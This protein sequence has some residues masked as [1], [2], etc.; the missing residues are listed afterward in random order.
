MEFVIVVGAALG[1]R[2][3]VDQLAKRGALSPRQ[4]AVALPVLWLVLGLGLAATGGTGTSWQIAGVLLGLFA[5]VLVANLWLAGRALEPARVLTR[6]MPTTT[7]GV[8]RAIREISRYLARNP[9]D[10]NALSN[11]G[12]A[13]LTLGMHA[14]ARA[15]LTARLPSNRMSRF[16]LTARA[17]VR[18][19]MKDVQG[20]ID[21]LSAAIALRPENRPPT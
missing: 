17:M 3:L 12:T 9:N 11:R 16:H 2:V 19:A 6:P 10:A 20:A 4:A 7:P 18:W 15:T 8:R 13:Y 5:V 21:D 14:E 1:A